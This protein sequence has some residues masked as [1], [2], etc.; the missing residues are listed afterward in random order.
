[1]RPY[2]A[3]DYNR[4]PIAPPGTKVVAHSSAD[5]HTTFGPHGRLGWYIVPSLDHYRCFKVYFTDILYECDVLKVYFFPP[6]TPFPT[7]TNND[8]LRQAAEDMLKLLQAQRLVATTDPLSFGTPVMNALC[9]VAKLLGH[10][11]SNPATLILPEP[12]ATPVLL[13][14]LPHRS[15]AATPP[16]VSPPYGYAS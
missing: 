6:Q 10:A 8:Y 15:Y 12:I 4:T 1:M 11:V 13:P 14:T 9:E 2:S 7:T 5:A 16:R 3:Y